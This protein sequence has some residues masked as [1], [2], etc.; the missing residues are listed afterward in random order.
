MTIALLAALF[1]IA[2]QAWVIY[3]LARQHGRT[4]HA[5]DELSARVSAAESAIGQLRAAVPTLAAPPAPASGLAVGDIA[6]TFSLPNVAGKTRSLSDY[7]G[8]RFVLIFFNPACGFC[9]QLAPRLGHLPPG[10][11]AV[12]VMSRGDADVNRSLAREHG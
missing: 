7:A 12:V 11:P 6:P 4:L 1:V 8:K 3:V 10:A 5:H 9:Q 2:L